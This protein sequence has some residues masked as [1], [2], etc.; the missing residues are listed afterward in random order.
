[1]PADFDTI[2]ETEWAYLAGLIDGEGCICVNIATGGA[3]QLRLVITQK[4]ED[5]LFRIANSFAAKFHPKRGTKAFQL[6]WSGHEAEAILRRVFPYLKWKKHEAELAI[7][8]ACEVMV[9]KSNGHKQDKVEGKFI[10]DELKAIKEA[11]YA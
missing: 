10:M 1:M 4:N 3:Y 7:A 5:D 9:G 2:P 6:N 8:F 11:S